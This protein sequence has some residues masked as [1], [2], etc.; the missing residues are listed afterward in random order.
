[1]SEAPRWALAIHGGAG[2]MHDLDGAP[3]AERPYLDA[4]HVVLD[5]GAAVLA[6]GGGALDAVETA[7]ALLE[8]EPLFNSGRGSVFTAEGRI[9]LDAAIMDGRTLAAGAVTCVRTVRN[10]VRLARAVLERSPHVLLAGDGADAFARELG[11]APVDSGYFWTARRWERFVAM[12][13]DLGEDVVGPDERST[14]TVGAVARD[15]AGHV[16]AATSTGGMINKHAGRVGDSPL[17]GAGTYADDRTCAVSATGT[18]EAIMRALV[19][20]EVAARMRLRGESVE[21]AADGAVME[22]LVRVGG[23]GS[24]GLVALDR[25]G[26]VAAP[27][28]TDGMYRGWVLAGGERDVRF[29]R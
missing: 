24:G 23:P 25:A 28:N 21:E 3:G 20:H 14:G 27:F 8:D 1:M 13:R 10:P 2:T 29:W 5:A 16:A 12:K 26:H 19:A 6:A 22:E 11:I 4:L 17:I 15:G 9:E 7:V 18:G